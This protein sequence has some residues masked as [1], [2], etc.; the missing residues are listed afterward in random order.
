VAVI[1]GGAG[2]NVVLSAIARVIGIPSYLADPL[3]IVVA[4]AL[5]IPTFDF[6]AIARI[7]NEVAIVR[8]APFM[9]HVEIVSQVAPPLGFNVQ[10]GLFT[11]KVML[12][13]Q[14]YSYSREFARRFDSVTA[15]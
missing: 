2:I 12:N 7:S 1:L 5:V 13:G 14:R 11:H 15:L 10:R 4:I 8:M 3:A 6:M 9:R